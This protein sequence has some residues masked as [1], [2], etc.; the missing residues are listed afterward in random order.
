MAPRI[1]IRYNTISE[2]YTYKKVIYNRKYRNNKLIRD[3][4]LV[5]LSPLRKRLELVFYKLMAS[6]GA[7]IK[8]IWLKNGKFVQY[9]PT[10][11]RVNLHNSFVHE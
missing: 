11:W 10:F 7:K 9:C 3:I 6:G 2:Y 1:N 8:I 4:V 5:V